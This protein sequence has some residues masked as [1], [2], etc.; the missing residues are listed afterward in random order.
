MQTRP[1]FYVRHTLGAIKRQSL[2]RD[3]VDW[4]T[5]ERETLARAASATTAAETLP[6]FQYA[7]GVVDNGQ[8]AIVPAPN[9]SAPQGLYGLQVV[10]PE[11]VVAVVFAGSA[12]AAAGIRPGD[13]I[14]AVNGKPAQVHPNP[15]MRGHLIDL[16]TPSV[17]LRV[18]RP[19]TSAVTDVMLQ[20]GGYRPLPAET[21]RLDQDL[22]YVE[23]PGISGGSDFALRIRESIYSTDASTVCGWVID[24]RRNSGGTMPGMLQALR[25]ILGDSPVGG[26]VDA[27][28]ASMPWTFP[29]EPDA[30]ALRPLAEPDPAVALLVGRLTAGAGEGLV[31]AFRGRAN[32]RTFGEPTWG[33][34][35][36]ITSIPLPDGAT[37]QLLT[38]READRHGQPRDGAIAPDETHAIDWSRI[39]AA[40]DPVLL[41]AGEWLRGQMACRERK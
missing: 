10:H 41:A 36:G 13:V 15:R 26:L 11:H 30:K 21:R 33:L 35:S 4:A 8:S 27:S 24:L 38:A 12:A 14:E 9:P 2:M 7:L 20:L 29:A 19:A 18:R 16:P 25:P 6:A 28:G 1:S 22:G 40:D 34:G 31:V 37:L 17:T 39:G 3:T 32:T 5:L 23:I